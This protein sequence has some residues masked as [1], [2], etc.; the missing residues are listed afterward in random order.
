MKQ[1]CKI[2]TEKISYF[3]PM[4]LRIF[5]YS[6]LSLEVK[7]VGGKLHMENVCVIADH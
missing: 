1:T 3:N 2:Y 5:T 6:I 4:F 7:W